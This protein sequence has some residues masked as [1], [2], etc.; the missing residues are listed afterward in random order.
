[1]T[2]YK[3]VFGK[4]SANRMKHVQTEANFHERQDPNE[5]AIAKGR[6]WH[7]DGVFEYSRNWH[8]PGN[9]FGSGSCSLM[10]RISAYGDEYGWSTSTRISYSLVKD[11][12]CT[13]G[14]RKKTT[15]CS[16]C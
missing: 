6:S 5:S 11:G 4:W 12:L 13:S 8:A 10:R 9:L 2:P 7:V 15:L 1:L 3:A 14:H 16:V